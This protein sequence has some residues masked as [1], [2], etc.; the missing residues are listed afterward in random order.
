MNLLDRYIIKRYAIAFSF[1]LLAFIALFILVDVIENIDQFI[2]R[3]VPALAIAQY[4]LVFMPEIAKLIAPI[5]ALLSA[6]YV[7]GVMSKQMELTAMKAGGISLYRILLPF[8]FFASVI[9]AVDFYFSGWLVPTVMREKQ[10]FESIQLGKN[11]WVGGSRSNINLVE[12]P[13]QTLNI[14]YYDD[15]QKT[16][17]S[18]SIQHFKG[19]HLVWRL[20]A[21]RMRYDTLVG[22]WK[23][24]NAYF[25]TIS[26]ENYET[27]ARYATLDTITVSFSPQDLSESAAALELM[28]VPEHHRYIQSREK[29]GFSSLEEAIVKFHTKISFPVACLIVALIGVPLSAQKKRSGIALEAGISLL[30]GFSYIGVQQIFATLGY[31]GAVNPVLAAWIPN[32]IF[33]VIGIVMLWKAQK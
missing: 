18:V 7:T 30:I 16:C 25:R 24:E 10:K 11:F 27:I 19:A 2:D 13:E 1:G 21:E 14:G 15:Y 17:F 6:L 5:S 9:T 3:H 20:D 23:M 29:S 22:K 31:K 28:T 8:F 26:N 4:Y 12:S 33:T 32:L